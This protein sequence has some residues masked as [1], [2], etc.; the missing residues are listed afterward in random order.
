MPVTEFS[1]YG[2]EFHLDKKPG[3]PSNIS[4]NDIFRESMKKT[5]AE[6][7]VDIIVRCESL[8]IIP[9]AEN[10]FSELFDNLIGLIFDMSVTANRLFLF[11]ECEEETGSTGPFSKIYRD[12]IIR[13]HSNFLA[14]NE[15]KQKNA[16]RLS[17]CNEIVL[18]YEGSFIVN[19]INNTGCLFILKLPANQI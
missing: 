7:P 18:N 11:V 13:F 16:L 9:G 12:Y 6:C 10:H 17:R 1:V 3:L 19:S 8:P 4:L 2:E 15:W 5:R 14:D